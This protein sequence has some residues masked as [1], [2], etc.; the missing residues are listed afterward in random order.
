MVKEESRAMRQ[1]DNAT[2]A[3]GKADRLIDLPAMSFPKPSKFTNNT[4]TIH[5]NDPADHSD[6]SSN[7]SNKRKLN[8]KRLQKG[9]ERQLQNTTLKK[10]IKIEEV[11]S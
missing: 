7:N 9:Q 4:S 11:D 5:L 2:A 8:R 6:Q 3:C 10:K 1:K